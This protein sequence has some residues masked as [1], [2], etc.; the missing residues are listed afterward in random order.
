GSNG[1]GKSTLLNVVAG[2][3]LPD[4]GAI[5]IGGQDVTRQPEWVRARVVGRV[6]QN[7]LDGTAGSMSVEENLSLALA[8]GRRHTLAR[9]VTASLRREFAQRLEPLGLGL[10]RRLRGQVGLLS[11]GQRQALTLLMATMVQPKVLLLDEHTANLDPGTAQVIEQLTTRLIQEHQL[12]TLMV[13]HNMQQ[14]LR[15][16]NRTLMMHEGEI[17]LDLQGDERSGLTVDDL[18]ARFRRARQ[19]DLVEDELLL[20]S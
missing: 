16:G 2:V 11:G 19:Q 4:A 8:R 18:V 12:P 10:E 9:G 5:A 3:F 7:P 6:F 20:T 17:V 1:A 15:I 13:T 14:A